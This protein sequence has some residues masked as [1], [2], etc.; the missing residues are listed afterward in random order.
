MRKGIKISNNLIREIRPSL[1][2]LNKLKPFEV[3]EKFLRERKCAIYYNYYTYNYRKKTEWRGVGEKREVREGWGHISLSY[4][5]EC[6]SVISR[7]N[8]K[9]IKL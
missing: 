4:K 8:K 1:S 5:E 2:K 7:V 3:Q 9:G 6:Q